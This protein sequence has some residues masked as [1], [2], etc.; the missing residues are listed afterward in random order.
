MRID[1][2]Y[3]LFLQPSGNLRR[4]SM[5]ETTTDRESIETPAASTIVRQHGR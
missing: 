1:D 4:P 5:L 2:A 3:Q